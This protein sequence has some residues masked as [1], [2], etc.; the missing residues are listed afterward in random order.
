MIT[1]YFDDE[2]EAYAYEIPDYVTSIGSD[3]WSIYSGSPKGVGWDIVDR[4]FTPLL[5]TEEI[6]F[7]RHLPIRESE[8]HELYTIADEQ[9]AK[10]DNHTLLDIEAEHYT[11]LKIQWLQYKMDVRRTQEQEGFPFE[12]TYPTRPDEDDNDENRTNHRL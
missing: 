11:R 5:S 12:V 10:C 9:I 2:G 6:Q 3:I 8:R 4:V 1:I 7:E